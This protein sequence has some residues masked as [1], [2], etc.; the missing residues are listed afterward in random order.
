M[1]GTST[2]KL[3]FRGG[4]RQSLEGF[5][6]ADWAACAVDRRSYTGYVF[7]YGRSMVSWEAKKQ[8][9]VALLTAEAEYMALTEATKE[10]VH[11]QQ[12]LEAR[13]PVR[14]WIDNQATEAL[15]KNPIVSRRSKLGMTKPVNF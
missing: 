7:K 13:C 9:T 10:A 3:V 1:K 5:A 14:I 6:D 12:L 15:G 4:G 2:S 11:L 8:K